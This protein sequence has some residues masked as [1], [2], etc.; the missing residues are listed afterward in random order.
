MIWLSLSL[1]LALLVAGG[2]MLHLRERLAVAQASRDY[3][4][5]A[6]RESG[7]QVTKLTTLW[8]DAER[9]ARHRESKASRQS[10]AALPATQP[11]TVE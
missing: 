8:Q 6:A 9:R 2:Y 10:R 5:I 4:H 3:W 11:E 7:E 1:V